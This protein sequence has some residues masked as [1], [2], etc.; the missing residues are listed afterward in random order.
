MK[1]R[2]KLL[3]LSLLTLLLP[4]SAWKLLQELERFLREGQETALLA[5]ANILAATLPMEF[6]GRLRF[7]PELATPLR[8]LP[9][10]PVLD[11]YADEWPEPGQGL[12]FASADDM[13]SARLLVGK[14]GG[15]IQLYFQVS[16]GTPV[17]AVPGLSGSGGDAIHLWLRTARGMQSWTVSPEAPGPIRIRSLGAEGGELEGYWLET[18][19]VTGPGPVS[20]AGYRLEVSLPVAV[21]AADPGLELA[22]EV[23]DVERA[24]GIRARSLGTARQGRPERWI[25]LTPQWTALSDWLATAAP[26]GTRTWLVDAA[27]WVLADSGVEEPVSGQTTW[28]QRLLY[29]M[30]ADDRPRIEESGFGAPVRLDAEAVAAALAGAGGSEWTQDLDN[31]VV[32]NTVA[33]PVTVQ[34]VIAGALVMQARTDG[35][36]FIT[37]RAIG[38]LL[39]TTLVLM[40]ILVAGLWYFASRLS[41]RVERLSSAVSQAMDRAIDRSVSEMELPL[42]GDRDELGEL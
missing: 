15:L 41:G 40:L 35:L 1:L 28:L 34:G 14:A 25:S 38:R 9:Q 13:V 22:F 29:R 16:D 26:S 12:E 42:V 24:G 3:A 21:Q 19:P 11:G 23:V 5:S 8:P 32:R 20:G 27:G 7:A 18:A 4:W 10:A 6:Q 36:L 37:N 17:R 33:V 30:V 2:S 31:A 39:L